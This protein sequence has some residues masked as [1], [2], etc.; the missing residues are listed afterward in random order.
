MKLGFAAVTL[1]FL[2]IGPPALAKPD[3]TAY[4]GKDAAREG[5][6]GEKTIING[7]DV[8]SNGAPP[9]RFEVIGFLTDR[10]HKSGIY[11]KIRMSSL[12]KEI[13][14]EARAHGGEAVIIMSAADDVVGIVA[15]SNAYANATG[16]GANVSSFAT[17]RPVVEQ[18][19]RFA[20]IRYL[21]EAATPP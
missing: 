6:G 13:V 3:F 2:L 15:G 9:R 16:Y 11:G 19:S 1:A 17:A 7:M 10:R 5:V 4:E 20:V 21:P 14:A 12:E 18:V 8:W